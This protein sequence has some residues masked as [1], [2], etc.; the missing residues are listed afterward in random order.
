MKETDL[1]AV[2]I[3]YLKDLKWDVHQ[4]VGGIDIVAVQNG[5]VWGIEC[6]LG[7]GLKVIEQATRN[8]VWVHHSSIAV[9]DR[10]KYAFA[11]MICMQLGIG[12]LSVDVEG[13]WG[14]RVREDVRARWCGKHNRAH[15]KR[16]RN[17][18]NDDT[19]HYA[20][21][22]S[23]S[24]KTW[25]PFKDTCREVLR[26]V[27]KNPGCTTKE[28]VEGIKHHYRTEK[29]ALGCLLKYGREG[30]IEGIEVVDGRPVRWYEAA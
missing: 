26:Y 17:R 12:M 8:R 1:A 2:V 4:E 19:R 10:T 24:P 28:L 13:K 21:A 15:I 18:L 22:G 16:L 14:R 7:L 23:P 6:K 3:E 20:T 5:L 25:T 11:E 27:H 9:P 30:V 29:S